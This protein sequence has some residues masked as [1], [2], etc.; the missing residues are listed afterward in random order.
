[1]THLISNRQ[2]WTIL[3]NLQWETNGPWRFDLCL[4]RVTVFWSNELCYTL[5]SPTKFLKRYSLMVGFWIL[6]RS[7][8]KIVLCYMFSFC[9]CSLFSKTE[10]GSI[11]RTMIIWRPSR[12]VECRPFNFRKCNAIYLGL[13][14]FRDITTT[15]LV[16]LLMVI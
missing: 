10:T 3:V 9:F 13:R 16:G 15:S 2:T 5:W 4:M 12:L 11:E 14:W 8:W 6:I 1:M 7:V